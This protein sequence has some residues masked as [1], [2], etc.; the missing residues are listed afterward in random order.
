MNK[1][2]L[3]LALFILSIS[4]FLNVKN[5]YCIFTSIT[6]PEV[7]SVTIKQTTS[8]TVVHET[9]DLNGTTYTEHSH[10]DH[11]NVLVGAQVTPPVLTNL[12]G[13]NIPQTQTVTLDFDNNV[14]TYRYTRKQYTLTIN[15]SNY[16]TTSTPSGTYYYGTPITLTAAATDNNGNQFVKWSDNTTN[17]NKSFT[18]TDNVT[19]GPIYGQTYTI[20]YEP[21]NG[22]SQ[23]IDNISE[24][25][26]LGTLPT[27]TNDDCV[28][29]TG[30]YHTRGCTSV[31]KFEG[32]YT[33]STFENQVNEDYVPT[34]NTTL[35]AKWNKIF[36]AKEDSP[37]VCTGNNYI[38][39]GIVMFNRLNADKDFI[40]KFTVDENDGYKG[41]NGVDRGTIFTDMNEK[42]EPF[43]GV[44]FYTS[45]QKKNPIYTMNI[46]VQGNKVKDSD[47]GYVTG[48]SVVIKKVNGIVYYNYNNGTDVQVNDFTNFANYFDNT[49][50]FCAGI[51]SSGATYRFF[52][53]T[54]SNLSVELIDTPAYTIHFDSNG[55]TGMM[56]NQKIKLGQNTTINSN[57]YTNGEASFTG[58][59]TQAD[60]SGTSYTDNYPITSDLGNDG[61]VIT[62]YAQWHFPEYFYVHFDANGGTGTMANQEFTIGDPAK[63]LTQNAFTRTGYEFRGWNTAADGSGT[64]YDD[65]ASVSDLSL[66]DGTIV[67]LYAEWM[68]IMYS[69]LGD[70][71]FDGTDNTFIDT[72]VN[73]FDQDPTNYTFD[74][75]FEIR[76][77]FKSVDADQLTVTPKQPTIF[78]VKD[79]SN[80]YMPGFNLRFNAN[81]SVTQ[82]TPGY[83][84]AGNT[85]GSTSLGSISINNAPID[86]VYKRVDGVITMQYK[87]GNHTSQ[88]FTMID[89]FA[90]NGWTLN[91]AFATN[92]AFGG[93]F[94]SNNQP[95]RFFKGT[96]ADI[97]ILM[98]E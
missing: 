32:W 48:Q 6:E 35:Y 67:P 2:K 89:Q 29:S 52:K 31:Y 96:L 33:E 88:V 58:W 91:Q 59:N 86:F 56:L 62:L 15:N 38:D 83:K 8:Y 55:G 22:D 84:W 39:T 66:V 37:L 74:K 78:N 98:E 21:N 11:S 10:I 77:T 72:G 12:E 82:M 45:G 36:Y 90:E 65:L 25:E 41:G 71:V 93:Y 17:L 63:P 42:G 64:H 80:P 95:G 87:Y 43:Q 13:F 7:N 94:D 4:S 3:Y 50:T 92:I 28:G 85:N 75:D 79:E 19:I 1:I 20:T 34:G 26:S 54:L 57:A 73:I 44:H 70:V 49:A 61:D 53:G 9:M 76:F 24:N 68:K 40:I 81:N 5:I 47:T 69:N 18:L 27:V 60:G 23:I 51:N 14:I 30:D 46:N 97:V 16:V